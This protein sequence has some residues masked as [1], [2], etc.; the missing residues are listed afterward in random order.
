MTK[1]DKEFI[2]QIIHI[3]ENEIPL[4]G[5]FKNKIVSFGYEYKNEKFTISYIIGAVIFD[6]IKDYEK[7]RFFELS[8]RQDSPVIEASQRVFSGLNNE[9]VK[10]MLSDNLLINLEKNI[11]ELIESLKEE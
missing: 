8:V 11:L 3:I 5:K 1:L 2:N 4:T 6:K 9:I 7:K 10:Y